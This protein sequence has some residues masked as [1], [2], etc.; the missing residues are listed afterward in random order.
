MEIEGRTENNFKDIQQVQRQILINKLTNLA[1]DIRKINAD[2]DFHYQNDKGESLPD[3]TV[4]EKWNN[5]YFVLAI[6]QLINT[7]GCEASEEFRTDE[8]EM[9]KEEIADQF[10][11]MFDTVA[12]LEMYDIFEHIF[13]KMDYNKTRKKRHGKRV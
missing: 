11:R 12:H 10:I 7:E 3:A 13:V 5:P 8:K 1:K 4:E 6:Q 9:F 2:N